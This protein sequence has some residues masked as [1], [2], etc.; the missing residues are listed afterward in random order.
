[1]IAIKKRATS[2]PFLNV[3]ALRILM[4]CLKG[5]ANQTF[6]INRTSSTHT[7]EKTATISNPAR[8]AYQ[9]KRLASLSV[10]DET[11]ELEGVDS[12]TCNNG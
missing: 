3:L 11:G 8:T 6:V 1:M 4:G 10:I 7:V 2:H 12:G 5:Q 9:V